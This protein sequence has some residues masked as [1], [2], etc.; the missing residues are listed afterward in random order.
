MDYLYLQADKPWHNFYIWYQHCRIQLEQFYQ[1]LICPCIHYNGLAG[2]NFKITFCSV[3]LLRQRTVQ[4]LMRC[5]V[6]WHLIWVCTIC[7]SNIHGALSWN[8]QH[9]TPFFISPIQGL[10][11][12][13]ICCSQ[14][15]SQMEKVG[16]KCNWL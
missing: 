7:W 9:S 10:P 1:R 4:D 3:G 16:V 13:R 11:W 14:H 5:N 15:F 6:M 2:G 12:L 8:D